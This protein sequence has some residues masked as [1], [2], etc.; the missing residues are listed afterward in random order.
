LFHPFFVAAENSILK[1]CSN[2][3]KDNWKT[4]RGFLTFAARLNEG[5]MVL[6]YLV[7]RDYLA[8]AYGQ[9]EVN[10]EFNRIQFRVDFFLIPQKNEESEL[11]AK[12]KHLADNTSFKLGLKLGLKVSF[13]AGKCLWDRLLPFKFERNV[14]EDSL[15][16]SVK[17]SSPNS[18]N[19]KKCSAVPQE[20]G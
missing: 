2:R 16:K 6:D 17:A 10:F 20:A 12:G 8:F 19:S 11:R 15:Q 9:P 7:F 13:W 4:A 18:P 14:S 3:E 1:C 5:R